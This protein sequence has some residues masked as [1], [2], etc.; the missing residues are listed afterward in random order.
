LECFLSPSALAHDARK[1]CEYRFPG[2]CYLSAFY[3]AKDKGYYREEDIDIEFIFMPAL[4]RSTAVLTWRHRLQR[5]CHRRCGCGGSWQPIKAVIF[6]MRS[7]VQGLMAKSEIKDLHQLKAKKIG[8]SS[9]GSTT[10][11][12]TRHILRKQGYEFGRD[13]SLVFV[14][15]EPGRLAALETAVIDAAMLSVRKIF[16]P[17]KKASTSWLSPRIFSISHK[18]VSVL[19]IKKSRKS[20]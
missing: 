14:A 1:K 2:E 10:D 13:Y 7:P 3:A 18:T 17:V 16:S 11:L 8:V 6:T 9:P 5:R 15:T 12:A 4:I 20:R 19:L